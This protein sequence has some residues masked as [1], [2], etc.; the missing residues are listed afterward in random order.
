[1]EFTIQSE[2]QQHAG[3]LQTHSVPAFNQNP[4]LAILVNSDTDHHKGRNKQQ[5]HKDNH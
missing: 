1:M 3:G 2:Q 5:Q 4:G